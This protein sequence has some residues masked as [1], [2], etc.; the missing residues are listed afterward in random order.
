MELPV[1][2]FGC[3]GGFLLFPT[4]SLTA[5][6]YILPLTDGQSF[7]VLGG[8]APWFDELILVFPA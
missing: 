1:P 5:F 3:A 2:F 6:T 7:A 8:A 4:D